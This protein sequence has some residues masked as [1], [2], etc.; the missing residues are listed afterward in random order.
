VAFKVLNNVVITNTSD[1]TNTTIDT[2]NVLDGVIVVSDGTNST[3]INRGQTL[4][5]S[6]T[7]ATS[8]TESNG[9]ISIDASG[10][11][12]TNISA[13]VNDVGYITSE[14]DNQTLSFVSPDLTIS[15]GN[16]VDLS[17]L[18]TDLTGYATE[19]Y[20]DQAEADA[21]SSAN[22]YT[23][24]RD[25]TLIGDSTVNGTI[26]NTI[27]NRI[28]EAE[29]DAN[30]YTDGRETAITTAYQTY[31]DQA[32][33]D[34]NTYTDGRETAITTA[35]QTYADTAEADANTYTDS[36]ETAITTAYQT[37]ADTAEA[38]AISTSA[39]DATSKANTAESNANTYTDGR[40]T[41]ITTAY[42]TYADTAEADAISTSATFALSAANAAKA[43]AN[44][45]TDGK[46]TKSYIDSLGI[47]ASSV[48]PNSVTLGTDTT[49]NYISTISGTLNEVEVIGSGTETS[50]VTLGLPNNVTV[51]NDLTVGGDLFVTGTTVSIGAANLSV[52]D[53][54]I[55]LNQG[56]AIGDDGT[57][58]TGTGL[59][60]A[61]FEGYFEG[62]TTTT[63][64]VRID[65]VGTPDTFEWSKDN[66]ATT[67]A[68]GIAITGVEQDL[69]NNI[70]FHASATT[71]HT[72]G[73][74]W[75]GT[76]APLNIDTGIF[77]NINTGT[78]APGYTHVGVFY[79][80]SA[81]S[82]KVFSEYDPEPNGD[83]NTG[84]ASF[85]LGEME[86][87][88]FVAREVELSQLPSVGNHAT[89]KTY[90]D[91][92][93]QSYQIANNLYADAVSANALSSANTYADTKLDATANAVSSSKW[94]TARTITLGG[95]LSGN[96]SIDGS[97]NV[98]L[99]ATV[100]DDSHTHSI[101]NVTGLQTALNGKVDD[102]QVLTNVPAGAVFTDT[103]TQRAIHDTPV[104]GATTTSISSN[105]AFDN[106]KTAVPAGAV[107][108]DTNTNNYISGATFSTANGILTL[109]RSGL[110]SLTVDLDGR[111]T[112]NV[113]ADNMNQ[114]VRTTD[115]PS[116]A[117][118]R[119]TNSTD[120][121][122][123]S[124]GHAFQTG[125]TSG[126]NIIID[127]NEIMARNNGATGN[128]HLQG[129]GGLIT[130]GNNTTNKVHIDAGAITA[131]GDITAYGTISDIRQKENI[132]RLENALDKVHQ[133]NG[134]TFNYLNR[135]DRM[136][137][138]MAQE[139]QAVLPEAVFETNKI[140]TDDGVDH[141]LAVRHGNMV[142]LLIEAI[143]EQQTQIEMLKQEVD[144][145]KNKV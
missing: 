21:I 107:F 53:N 46:T 49:G 138:V 55:Y 47:Q 26:G 6:G 56:D 15:N 37:Y 10:E 131:T 35:Y 54:F 44:S 17:A 82:W 22:I 30:T 111:F 103:N 9:V 68:T 78:S 11:V 25:A 98:T 51:G 4:T 83:I 62:T 8:V 42:Q 41:A 3:S 119:A 116:F 137:G 136:T 95:D 16:S 112:D 7:S 63:Y 96:V 77:S 48:N 23:D 20:V 89:N 144:N 109:E 93:D 64:Y 28:D 105:W 79:D 92:A 31:A 133:L 71:G 117:T 127:T 101:A 85:V 104:N 66:F 142:G 65:S 59:D 114:N 70:K 36:R 126:Q 113:Y 67:E 87:D 121:S 143:K 52:D 94:N 13:F 122:L 75:S 60:D 108:T 50:N 19:A 40:E 34:A 100:A 33:A 73:D 45:Y 86:A 38:D 145:L 110:S 124:T 140:E 135:E 5:F 123:T 1:V 134:Y 99:T 90:V 129:E 57:I 69:D 81:S 2:T 80:A 128:L 125:S 74:V 72:L 115:S 132:E 58:F 18:Q 102:S 106:V 120:A 118:I 139:V 29:A 24:F 43:D 39:I 76:A 32:E 91:A 97:Q 14:T 141:I 12:P 130:F 61:S 88:C 27:K 84:D